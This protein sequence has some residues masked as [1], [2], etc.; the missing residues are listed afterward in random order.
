MEATIYY[1]RHNRVCWVGVILGLY[2][3]NGKEKG[4]C[5]RTLGL[6]RAHTK[7][8]GDYSSGLEGL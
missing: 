1:N 6:Y 7:E 5:C 4:N 8:N 2:D 3:D